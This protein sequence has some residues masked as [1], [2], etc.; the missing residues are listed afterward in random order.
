MNVN[1]NKNYILIRALKSIKTIHILLVIFAIIY[2]VRM[3][4]IHPWYDELYTYYSFISRGPVYA[5][6]HWPLPNNHVGYSALSACLNWTGSPTI[7][8]RGISYFAAV[9]NIYLVYALTRRVLNGGEDDKNIEALGILAAILYATVNIVHTISVQ[10]R[11]YSL[12]TS[13]F[14]MATLMIMNIA[15]TPDSKS[16]MLPDENAKLKR[17]GA[18]G[19]YAISLALGIYLVPSSTFWVFPVCVVGGVYLLA[20]KKLKELLQLILASVIAAVVV[21]GLYTI[22]WLAIGSNLLSKTAGSIYYGIYQI[23]IIKKAPI[24]SLKA[25]IDYMLA[26]PYIQSIPRADVINGLW[27]YLEALFT[28]FYI[29]LGVP[30]IIYLAAVCIFCLIRFVKDRTRFVELFLAVQIIA[31]PLLMIIQ[32]KAPY[33]RVYTFFGVVVAVSVVWLINLVRIDQ[34]KYSVI[35]IYVVASLVFM[36]LFT[37]AYNCTIGE[38]EDHILEALN[39]YNTVAREVKD[40]DSIFYVDDYQKYVLKFYFD[41]EP[42]E[43]PLEEA[44]YVM[45]PTDEMTGVWPFFYTEDGFDRDY[46]EQC[47]DEEVKTSYYVIYQRNKVKTLAYKGK[48]KIKEIIDDFS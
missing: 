8:L 3:Y 24:N 48:N 38:R 15:N 7:A 30:M 47:F 32:C 35:S 14:M 31:L 37:G 1:E 23:D 9:L 20:N 27:N 12:S 43:E 44:D 41:A 25:G 4:R 18:F 11:G 6:I 34:L 5:A 33:L 13:C 2:G 19:L 10:G 36:L 22:I 39:S 16:E 29:Y 46:V 45:L 21:L 17:T 42:L 26:S 40:I 28:Q